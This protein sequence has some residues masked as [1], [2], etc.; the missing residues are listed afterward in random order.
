MRSKAFVASL[1]VASAGHM[2][3]DGSEHESN[4]GIVSETSRLHCCC[5]ACACGISICGCVRPG[6]CVYACMFL[7]IR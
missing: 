1:K 7:D 6:I 2:V 3:H 5:L 4:Y